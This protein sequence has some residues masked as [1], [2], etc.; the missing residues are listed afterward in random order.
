MRCKATISWESHAGVGT[1]FE[2]VL[3][4]DEPQSDSSIDVDI[5]SDEGTK[6]LML[7]EDVRGTVVYVEDNE[8]NRQLVSDLS[9]DIN[10][11]ELLTSENAEQGLRVASC[12]LRSAASRISF[13][14]TS[15]CQG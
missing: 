4:S 2:I 3:P 12:E 1:T 8:A 13:C 14:L 11:I 15:T 6:I 9:A 10:G 7:S 5:E